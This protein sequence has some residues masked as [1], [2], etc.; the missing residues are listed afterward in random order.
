[1]GRNPEI[2]NIR[3]LLPP[4]GLKKCREKVMLQRPEAR[5]YLVRTSEAG[6]LVQ[7]LEHREAALL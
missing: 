3:K 1:M 4:L 2:N 5:G 7:Q 6:L